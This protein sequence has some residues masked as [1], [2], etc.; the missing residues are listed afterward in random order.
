MATSHRTFCRI[1]PPQCGM[2]VETDNNR[3]LAI[4]S[5]KDHPVTQGYLCYKGVT[6]QDLH[7]G[8][9]RLLRARKKGDD[10]SQVEISTEQALDEIHTKLKRLIERHGPE[11]VAI[12]FGTGCASNAL[13][14]ATIKLWQQLLGTPWLFSSMTIDQ[15]AKWVAAGRIGMFATGLHRYQ[16][17]DAF[18]AAGANPLVAHTAAYTLKPWIKEAKAKGQKIIVVDP[19]KTEFARHADI[20]LAIVPGTDVPVFAAMLNEIFSMGWENREFCERFVDSVDELKRAVSSF[21]IE[22]AAK[23]ADVSAEDLRAAAHI[24]GKAKRPSATSGTGANFTRHSNLVEHLIQCLNLITGAFRT[25]GTRIPNAG[26]VFRD[27]LDKELVIPP[28]RS[29]EQ[30]PKLPASGAGSMFG[31][32][33]TSR[34]PEEILSGRDDRIRALF[35]IGGNP[36]AAIGDPEKCQRA[37]EKL[38]L[39][40]T[41]DPAVTKMVEVSDYAIPS[42][43]HF[44]REDITCMFESVLY[45][46][47]FA[48]ITE[49]LLERPAGTLEDWEFFWESAKRLGKTLEVKRPLYGSSPI[50]GEPRLTLDM[51]NKPATRDIIKWICAQNGNDYEEIAS[52]PSGVMLDEQD[53]VVAAADEDQTARLDA[54]P[55]DVAQEIAAAAADFLSP[56]K[57]GADATQEYPYLLTNRRILET[58]NGQY[59]GSS[60]TRRRYKLNPV[61]VNPQDLEE[62]GISEGDRLRVTSANGSITGLAKSDRTMRSGTIAISHM[63]GT[64]SDSDVDDPHSGRL[65]SID[66]DLQEINFMPLYSGIPVA[67]APL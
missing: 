62:A 19:R 2:V 66:R 61:F 1:C 17:S 51:E 32:Y 57:P 35:V 65:V 25:A 38:D 41:L 46:Q 20:H 63:W 16:D 26:M 24:F 56:S 27:P 10:G 64:K 53:I 45:P 40:V 44:E 18:L 60:R 31:E 7:N 12:Y 39:L 49:A 30:E 9:G 55:P 4:T 33:P 21:T 36:V 13:S 5:D 59:V 37:F 34:L 3:I 8:E 48:Q 42:V 6:T 28:N 43:L 29:W 14:Q 47:P 58:I 11:S 22:Q 52:H 23:I 15:S 50:E 67:I 54:C